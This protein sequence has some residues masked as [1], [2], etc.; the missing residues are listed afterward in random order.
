MNKIEL[1]INKRWHALLPKEC[2]VLF[3]NF[4]SLK[5]IEWFCELTRTVPAPWPYGVIG[6]EWCWNSH[7]SILDTPSEINT[8]IVA[9]DFGEW[10][11]RANRQR[12]LK[13]LHGPID[14]PNVPHVLVPVE[15]FVESEI[16]ANRN[17][18]ME[19]VQMRILY[20]RDLQFT[21]P[22]SVEHIIALSELLGWC[23][24]SITDTT[25]WIIVCGVSASKRL[26]EEIQYE[27]EFGAL[28]TEVCIEREYGD[29]DFDCIVNK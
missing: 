26:P 17:C 18:N 13:I 5:S 16:A 27:D 22:Q 7:K 24:T 1:P 9:R 11:S 4:Y 20:Y 8:E 12:L 29:R 19:L 25:H 3:C 14:F 6:T 23:G 28:I 10:C 2:R 15:P 21:D